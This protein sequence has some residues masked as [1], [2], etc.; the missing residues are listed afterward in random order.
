VHA[1]LSGLIARG[2]N[3]A[4]L[5]RTTDGNG[6]ATQLRIVALLHRGEK[7][8]HVDMDDLALSRGIGWCLRFLPF[9]LDRFPVIVS[10]PCEHDD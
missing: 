4:A 1:K 7:C 9:G 10:V 5:A 8:I 2:R 3:D 6:F